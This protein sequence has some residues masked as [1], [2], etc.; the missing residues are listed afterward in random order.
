MAP[1]GQQTPILILASASPRRESLLNLAGY[2]PDRIIPAHIDEAPMPGELPAAQAK[3][4]AIEKARAVAEDH[5]GALVLGADTVVACGRRILPKAENEDQARAFLEMLSG[6]RHR[7]Y[8]GV[9]LIGSDGN[10]HA[11]C[12]MTAVTFKRLGGEDIRGY[13]DS[14][15]WRDKAG[16][17][18]IQG[19]AGAFVRRLN[20]SYPNVVGLPVFEVSAMLAGLGLKPSPAAAE[21]SQ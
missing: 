13:I 21:K 19:R 16:A 14:G 4:L 18:A 20:G 15:E 11:K 10:A 6:R 9:C 1:S 3:R 7:V 17:Y 8:G 5:P 2:P 12:V